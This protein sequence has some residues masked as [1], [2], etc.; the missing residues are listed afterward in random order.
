MFCGGQLKAGAGGF[1]AGPKLSTG[2]GLKMGL[3]SFTGDQ[4]IACL[5]GT[6]IREEH[7]ISDY[8]I[9]APIE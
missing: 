6:A 7:V 9:C 8:H 2:A 3:S 1:A 4:G 5:G